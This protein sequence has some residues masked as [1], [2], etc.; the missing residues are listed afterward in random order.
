MIYF[1]YQKC[2]LLPRHPKT[3]LPCIS[4]LN[5]SYLNSPDP[6]C[7]SLWVLIPSTS[8]FH[9][10][11][12]LKECSTTVSFFVLF[13][14]GPPCPIYEPNSCD[15]GTTCYPNIYRCD[16]WCDCS[17]CSD[18]WVNNQVTG[19]K[20]TV[21]N[22]QKLDTNSYLL[23]LEK[24]C[25]CKLK[26]RLMTFSGA[27]NIETLYRS[28]WVSWTKLKH[29]FNLFHRSQDCYLAASKMANT[30]MDIKFQ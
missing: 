26:V 21:R 28:Q 27:E 14:A 12:S 23:N 8:G 9:S 20:C 4:R 25:E 22:L 6:V 15:G 16:G 5:T 19:N 7:S 13:S 2:H 1:L 17:D 10:S 3:L 30:A 11:H 29:G 18:A 24:R